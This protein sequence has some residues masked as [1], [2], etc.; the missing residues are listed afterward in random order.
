[1]GKIRIAQKSSEDVLRDSDAQQDLIKKA[2]VK[3]KGKKRIIEMGNVFV[4]TTYNN[5]AVSFADEMGNV[6]AWCTSG[7]AGFK[8]PRKATPYAASRVVELVSEKVMKY[9]F[10]SLNLVISGI[11]TGRDAAIRSLTGR[12]GDKVVSIKDVTPVPH[13]GCRPRKPRRT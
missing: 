1:M 4:N 6:I 5:I 10:Q 11:G 2:K 3:Q 9:E 8:G 12:Y 13:N 7:A